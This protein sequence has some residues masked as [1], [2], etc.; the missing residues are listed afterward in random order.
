MP[1]LCLKSRLLRGD[2]RLAGAL[3]DHA[4]HVTKGDRGPHIRKI[5]GAILLLEGGTIDGA[6]IE[7]QRHGPTTA[8]AVLA[9]KNR[10]HII[11][12]SYQSTADEIAGIM[13]TG[14]GPMRSIKS[15]N[16]AGRFPTFGRPSPGPPPAGFPGA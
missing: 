8:T 10:R 1:S 15:R 3:L 5:Q 2:A 4:K 14:F 7:G 11:N 6:E 16:L 12:K 9:Y 13:T